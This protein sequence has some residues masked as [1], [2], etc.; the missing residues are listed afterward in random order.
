MHPNSDTQFSIS[1]QGISVFENETDLFGCRLLGISK[2]GGEPLPNRLC[3]GWLAKLRTAEAQRLSHAA[4]HPVI[5]YLDWKFCVP[6]PGFI[7]CAALSDNFKLKTL[8]LSFM[9]EVWLFQSQKCQR[10][11][12]LSFLI[13]HCKATFASTYLMILTQILT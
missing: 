8:N 9:K 12:L 2:R 4:K 1:L 3:F 10:F 11:I 5:L 13:Q 7:F 6:E